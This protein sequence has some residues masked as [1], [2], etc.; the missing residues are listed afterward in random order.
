MIQSNPFGTIFR[1]MC[2]HMSVT[3]PL[4]RLREY[5]ETSGVEF[6]AYYHVAAFAHPIIPVIVEG[7]RVVAARWGLIPHW[8]RDREAAEKIR[9]RTVNARS[10]TVFEKPSFRDSARRRR[11][12]IPVDG[13]FE[14]HERDRKKY[15]YYI[16]HNADEVFCLAGIWSEWHD[17]RSEETVLTFSVLTTAANRM[18]AEIHNVKKRMPV[19]VSPDRQDAWWNG[20]IGP[21]HAKEFFAMPDDLPIVA[22]PVSKLLYKPG[23]SNVPAVRE[24]FEYREL[25]ESK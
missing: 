24:P 22:H 21:D 11:C 5:Y 10:E 13:F 19:I 7:P 25:I 2:Y 17:R 1:N 14:S 8:A 3:R 18:M 12:L 15:P 4:P 9:G 16:H 6:P 23:V 20:E